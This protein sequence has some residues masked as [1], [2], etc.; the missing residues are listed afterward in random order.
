MF[1]K[2]DLPK[3]LRALSYKPIMLNWFLHAKLPVR[4]LLEI[5]KPDLPKAVW[6]L[7]VLNLQFWNDLFMNT[8]LL[9]HPFKPWNL[10]CWSRSGTLKTSNLSV[11][12]NYI[13]AAIS[14]TTGNHKL[15]PEA[16]QGPRL[17]TCYKPTI[18][19]ES[20][21]AMLPLRTHPEIQESGLPKLVWPLRVLNLQFR[22]NF[23]MKT[24]L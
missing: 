2:A 7:S 19:N 3:L 21:V 14:N 17:Q 9:E 11:C 1:R 4:A 20:V 5:L 12:T 8:Y 23:F 24:Y 10:T 22:M 18:L 6:P 16:A 15:W 13:K